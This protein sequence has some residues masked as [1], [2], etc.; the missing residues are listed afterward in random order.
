MGSICAELECWIG[1]VDGWGRISNGEQS[2]CGRAEDEMRQSK[3]C[4]EMES[5]FF[6]TPT[7]TERLACVFLFFIH[8]WGRTKAPRAFREV[9]TDS[10]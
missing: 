7:S 9:R 2:R 6:F 8:E 10:F 4:G 5:N 3:R 1:I